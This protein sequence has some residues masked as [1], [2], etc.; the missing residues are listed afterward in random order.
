MIKRWWPG[1]WK[2]K[3]ECIGKIW[4]AGNAE[5]YWYIPQRWWKLHWYYLQ[6]L[7]VNI[8]EHK[9]S[10][11][12]ITQRMKND[13]IIVKFTDGPS[14]DLL[15]SN[16][17]KLKEKSIKDLD[18]RNKTSIYIN[19][20]LSTCTEAKTVRCCKTDTLLILHN[21]CL[22]V[23]KWIPYNADNVTQKKE[24]LTAYAA[25]LLVSCTTKCVWD[26]IRNN[27]LNTP[28]IIIFNW[29]VPNVLSTDRAIAV[30]K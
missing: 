23:R 9:K 3:K 20:S 13:A 29:Y 26:W 5:G 24:I 16:N 30:L 8:N 22:C 1:N 18:Y 14:H 10:K 17:L 27:S 25:V 6:N 2:N 4:L 28:K 21:L 11:I 19:E 12:K 15:Y 7:R